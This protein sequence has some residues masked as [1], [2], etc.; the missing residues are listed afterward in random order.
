MRRAFKFKC[1]VGQNK[2]KH[3]TSGTYKFSNCFKGQET[4]DIKSKHF[5]RC[6]KSTLHQSFK[7]IRVS[8]CKKKI[9]GDQRLAVLNEKRIQILSYIYKT[10]RCKLGTT[11]A[12]SHLSL[13][14]SNIKS[15]ISSN[16]KRKIEE[17]ILNSE[18]LDGKLSQSGFWKIKK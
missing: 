15:I 2:F 1:P 13:I 11:I 7:K 10:S 14:E 6:L 4:I 3:L 18:S 16:N 17:I 5:F 9:Y 12:K 8:H